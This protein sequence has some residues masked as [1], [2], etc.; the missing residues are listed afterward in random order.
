MSVKPSFKKR[1]PFTLENSVASQSLIYVNLL[2]DA[3]DSK[4]HVPIV[5]IKLHEDSLRHL[6]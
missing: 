5:Y 4:L 2:R 1:L 6:L 3:L